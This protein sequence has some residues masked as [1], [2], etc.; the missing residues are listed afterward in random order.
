MLLYIEGKISGYAGCDVI[1][2]NAIRAGEKVKL[3]TKIQN[4]HREGRK[5]NEKDS[6]KSTFLL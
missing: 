6:K 5:S 2:Q 4:V 1:V 3:F